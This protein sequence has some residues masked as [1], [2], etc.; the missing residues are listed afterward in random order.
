VYVLAGVDSSRMGDPIGFLATNSCHAYKRVSTN[1]IS[2]L[3]S[4]RLIAIVAGLKLNEKNKNCNTDIIYVLEIN[5]NNEN[6]ENKMYRKGQRGT[7]THHGDLI[8]FN[9]RGETESND[10]ICQM[11]SWTGKERFQACLRSFRLMIGLLLG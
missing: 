10:R 8:L 3:Q 9:Y 6:N 4:K 11:K 2:P 5:E 7:C 1:R